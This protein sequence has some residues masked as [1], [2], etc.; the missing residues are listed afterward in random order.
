[1]KSNKLFT[2]Q[3]IYGN[4]TFSSLKTE[5]CEWLTTKEAAEH[6]RVNENTLRNI[7]SAGNI[8]YYKFG[9]RLRFLKSELNLHLL[10]NRR[11]G[12]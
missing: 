11:G 10:K 8:P 4:D 3:I 9:R 1:M 7:V 5:S 2:S 12:F 6:L